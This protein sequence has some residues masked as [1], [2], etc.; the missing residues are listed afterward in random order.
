MFDRRLKW[1]ARITWLRTIIVI[2][3]IE[4]GFIGLF[5]TVSTKGMICFAVVL[6]FGIVVTGVIDLQYRIMNTKVGLLK[7][8]KL[9]RL[10]C[11]GRPTGQAAAPARETASAGTNLWHTLPLSLREDV[12]WYLVLILVAAAIALFT[13]WL[14][15]PRDVLVPTV[16]TYVSLAPDGAGT[17]M[18][19][20]SYTYSG[21][22]PRTSFPF[23]TSDANARIRWVDSQGRELPA[24]V[25]TSEGQRHYTV[26]LVEP[27]MPGGQVHYT[28]VTKTP[29]LATIKD[30]L[31]TYRGERAFGAEKDRSPPAPQLVVGPTLV[32]S[33]ERKAEF[34]ETVQLPEGAEIVKVDPKPL[35][36]FIWNGTPARFFTATRG[37]NEAFTYTI[38]YRL[39]KASTHPETTK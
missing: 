9:L 25:S 6:L 36:L 31:W 39:P 11:L 16:E 2:A 10:E 37:R 33:R 27:V 7:E 35:G 38:Q 23:T 8:I 19:K 20:V 18:M 28:Q 30:D 17:E 13:L 1:L 32:D 14:G 21:W 34:S 24:T 4:V 29:A 12:E 5:L 22:V 26:R 15:I 3:V